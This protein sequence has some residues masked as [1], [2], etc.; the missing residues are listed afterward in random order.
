[1]PFKGTSETIGALL[2]G[3]VATVA[4]ATGWVSQV[5]AGLLVLWTATRSKNRPDA[6]TLRETGIDMVSNSPFGIAGPKGMD[7]AVVK[8]VQHAFT[9]GAEDSTYLEATTKLDHE[10]AYMHSHDC[11]RYGQFVEKKADRGSRPQEGVGC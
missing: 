3:H 5:N 2:G 8:I 7:P 1:V 4:D 10:P 6:P 9:K 11:R